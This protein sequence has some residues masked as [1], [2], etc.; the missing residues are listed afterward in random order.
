[1]DRQD[2]QMEQK[3]PAE[4]GRKGKSGVGRGVL[5][6][7]AGTLLVGFAAVTIGCRLTG[8]TLLL[9]N[10]VPESEA[11]VLD[12]DTIQ[13]VRELEAY[14]DLY[15]YDEMDETALKD[16]IYEGLISGTRG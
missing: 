5:Y 1:M 6:G 4:E 11:S 9:T 16:G 3:E 14:A 15:Y 13:K 10:S 2:F 7:I 12:G 8:T